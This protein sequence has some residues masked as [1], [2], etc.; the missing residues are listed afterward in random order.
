LGI[1][2][3]VSVTALYEGQPWVFANDSMKFATGFGLYV[4][5]VGFLFPF[6]MFFITEIYFQN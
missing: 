1:A 4:A 2:S 5:T 3:L 6:Y